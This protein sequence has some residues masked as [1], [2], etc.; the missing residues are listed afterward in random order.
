MRITFILVSFNHARFLGEAL[1]SIRGQTRVPDEVILCDDGSSDGSAAVL[2]KFAAEHGERLHVKLIL[3]EVNRGLGA[4]LNQAFAAA[5][6]DVWVLQAADDISRSDR[7]ERTIERFEAAGGRLRYLCSNATVVDADSVER[8]SYFGTGHQISPRP[9]GLVDGSVGVLGATQTI[10]RELWDCFGPIRDGIYQED[11]LLSF[12]AALLGE[13]E[14]LENPLVSYRFHGANLHFSG[15]PQYRSKP[16]SVSPERRRRWLQNRV[17][18]GRCRIGDLEKIRR[19]PGGLRTAEV[20]I[21]RI[22]TR[23]LRDAEVELAVDGTAAWRALGL[24]G[25]ACRR[26]MAVSRGIRIFLARVWPSAYQLAL[27]GWVAA[28][29]IRARAGR[30]FSRR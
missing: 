30:I 2:R 22:C 15:A 5:Q 26:G 17:E 21:D 3:N 6:G 11:V 29:R 27:S 24:V 19:W 14:Y 25:G 23:A 28:A 18:L 12:R 20:G 1:R 8:G 7:V 9:E 10:H 4:M 16:A 13:I